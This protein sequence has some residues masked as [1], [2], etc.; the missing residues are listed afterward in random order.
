MR[1]EVTANHILFG[2]R[3]SCPYCPIALAIKAAAPQPA[4]G[5]VSVMGHVAYV[6][7]TAYRLPYAARSFIL[8]FDSGEPVEPFEFEMERL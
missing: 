8:D 4:G 6:G 1:V 7:E 2:E 5:I 3:A